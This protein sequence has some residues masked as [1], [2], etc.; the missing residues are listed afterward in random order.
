MIGTPE[1]PQ[2]GMGWLTNYR[3]GPR[4]LGAADLFF[5]GK[6]YSLFLISYYKS[7]FYSIMEEFK[8]INTLL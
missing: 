5:I 2:M 7:K 8:A 3:S 4:R 1:C 6:F